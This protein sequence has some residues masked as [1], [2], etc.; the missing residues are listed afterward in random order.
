LNQYNAQINF[1]NKTI[2]WDI[3]QKKR[4]TEFA[5]KDTKVVTTEGKVKNIELI[6]EQLNHVPLEEEEK[7]CFINLIEK[8]EYIFSK[9]PGKIRQ[10]ECRIRVSPGEPY[11]YPVPISK[12]KKMD[13]EIQRMLNL[14]IIE[15]SSSPWSSPIVGVEKRN[16]Y[17]R[18]CIDAR[19]INKK[20]IPDKECPINVVQ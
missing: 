16:G 10:Y 5:D 4:I 17:I 9:D 15:Q 14:D 8:Y 7:E 19:Q 6:E 12:L 2:Q 18:L 3:D 13:Q 20:I 11:P 1:N